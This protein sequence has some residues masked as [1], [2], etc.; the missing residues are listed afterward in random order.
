MVSGFQGDDCLSYEEFFVVVKNRMKRQVR[1][2][3]KR[4]GWESFKACF[5]E[6]M[7]GAQF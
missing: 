3:F 6:E 1:K 7:R 2:S 5:R 4:Q